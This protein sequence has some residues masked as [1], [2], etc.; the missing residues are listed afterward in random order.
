MLVGR[1]VEDKLR[2]ETLEYGLHPV[3]VCD[4]G[5]KRGGFHSRIRLAHHQP[6]V[7]L[8]TLRGVDEHHLGRS[9]RGYLADYLAA[10]AS[11]GTGDKDP[12]PLQIG[13]H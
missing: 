6:D 13:L 12:G 10:D 3:L 11:G 4:T 1:R 7:V 9:K 2:T 5:D 8:G